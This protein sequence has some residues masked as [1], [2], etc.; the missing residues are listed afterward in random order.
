MS[1]VNR[2]IGLKRTWFY[3]AGLMFAALAIVCGGLLTIHAARAA[4]GLSFVKVAD[5]FS[6][7]VYVTSAG[8]GSG[9]LFVVEKGGTIKIIQAGKVLAQ[10]FLDISDRVANTGEAGLLSVAFPPDYASGGYFFVYYNHKD[11]IAKPAPTDAGHN[12]GKDTVIARFRVTSDPNQ[13]DPASEQRILVRN[14][15]Y[16]NHNGGL[17]A[18][19]PD[20]YLYVGLG[21]GGSGGDPQNQAQNLSTLLGKILRI[22]VG[23]QGTYTIPPTNPFVA[24]SGAKGEIWDYGLRNPWRWSFDRV[25]GDLWIGDVGQAK[26][27]EVDFEP[28]AHA[29][30]VNYGWRCQEGLHD[31]NTTPPCTGTLTPPI[32][33]YDHSLGDA[34]TGGYVYRGSAAN[35]VVGQYIY[36]D[37]GSGRIWSLAPDGNGWTPPRLELDTDYAISSFGEDEAGE[38]YLVDFNGAIYK[39]AAPRVSLP[40]HYYIPLFSRQ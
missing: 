2:L 29:G 32:A 1:I 30:G 19:G 18:F 13:A 4:S 38:L 24:N 36:A 5:G 33:E 6:Q 27:E 21:D 28:K 11:D 16:I 14:Q 39:L 20:G 9:R 34:I 35:S 15:P 31:Y 26:Y 7:P 3:G 10:P 23:P 40:E 22:A 17:I 8:D 12:E 25:T 37:Y